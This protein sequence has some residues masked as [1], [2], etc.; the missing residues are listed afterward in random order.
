[1]LSTNANAQGGTSIDNAHGF[2]SY[3]LIRPHSKSSLLGSSTIPIRAMASK[4]G[5]FHP[6]SPLPVLPI[7]NE[8]LIILDDH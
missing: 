4:N 8:E 7:T 6:P 5:I 1:M 2:V 3:C